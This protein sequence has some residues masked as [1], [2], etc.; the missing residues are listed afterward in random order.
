M[1]APA[2][3]LAGVK[4][5]FVTIAGTDPLNVDFLSTTIPNYSIVSLPG[6]GWVERDVIGGGTQEFMFA[7]QA[8]F[9]TAAEAERLENSGFYETLSD[10]L[11]AQTDAGTLPEL[12]S[13]KTSERLETVGG[14]SGFIFEQGSSDNGVY[15]ITCRLEYSVT[16]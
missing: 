12:P 15:Q 5:F 2:S 11:D 10:W 13:G 1:T 14:K 16:A 7:F 4:A 9:S 6:G 3:I 8:M